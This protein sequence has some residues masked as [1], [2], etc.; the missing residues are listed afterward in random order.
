[1]QLEAIKA[2]KSR[3]RIV[4]PPAEYKGLYTAANLLKYPDRY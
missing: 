2:L 4:L 1:V 3:P